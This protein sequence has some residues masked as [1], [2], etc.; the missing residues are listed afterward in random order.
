MPNIILSSIENNRDDFLTFSNDR[1]NTPTPLQEL[2]KIITGFLLVSGIALP[3]TMYHRQ[4][5]GVGSLFMSVIGGM[6]VYSDIIVFIWFFSE[7][8]DENDDFNF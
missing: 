5:I 7:H 1:G 4:L 6:I 2:A 8:E 3:L